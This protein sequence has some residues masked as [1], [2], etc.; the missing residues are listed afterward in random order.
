M[1]IINNEEVQ[2]KI[3]F[4]WEKH[5]HEGVSGALYCTNSGLK[6]IANVI[7]MDYELMGKEKRKHFRLDVIGGYQMGVFRKQ[8]EY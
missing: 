8:F 2:G 1:D 6:Q 3:R 4:L 7:G 5:I